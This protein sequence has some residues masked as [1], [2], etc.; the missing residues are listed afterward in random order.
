MQEMTTESDKKPSRNSKTLLWNT[1]GLC[2]PN[3]SFPAKLGESKIVC[4]SR[5][6]SPLWQDVGRQMPICR[7][8]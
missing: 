5:I 4:I 8:V 7:V 2:G 3:K 1:S 6:A